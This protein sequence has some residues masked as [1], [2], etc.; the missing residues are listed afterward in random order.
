MPT[1]PSPPPAHR[2]TSKDVAR[3]AGVSQSTV[4]LVLA[5]KWRGRVSPNTVESVRGAAADLGYRPNTAARSLRLGRTRSVLLVVPVLTSPFFGAVHTGAANVAA[6]RDFGIVVYP[7][8]DGLDLSPG[9]FAAGPA[10]IDGI[11]ASSMAAEPLTVLRSTGPG[12]PGLPLVMLDS[13]PGRGTTTVNHDVADNMRALTEHLVGL[14]HRRFARL[15]SAVP[16]WTFDVRD[17]AFRAALG[18]ATLV[19][20][21]AA[22][23]RLDE[24]REA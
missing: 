6:R 11:L 7:T 4:S 1:P 12:S 9:P 3:L 19:A 10:A 15:R 21:A 16:S 23:L 8:R 13:E 22:A 5:D 17:A 14:G 2:P 20:D 24:A 18:P